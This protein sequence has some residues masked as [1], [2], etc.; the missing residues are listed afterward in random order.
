MV[1]TVDIRDVV[2]IVS[3]SEVMFVPVD[4]VRGKKI[5]WIKLFRE[6][7][8]ATLKN[9]KFT[10]DLLDA[11]GYNLNEVQSVVKAAELYREWMHYLSD[12]DALYARCLNLALHLV[13][14]GFGIA[15]V[16]SDMADGDL[17][18]G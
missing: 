15:V 8:G 7:T 9:S 2:M 3:D 4:Q 13:N 14:Q 5:F 17:S 11:R 1:E 18:L 12:S 10:L 6:L 16:A